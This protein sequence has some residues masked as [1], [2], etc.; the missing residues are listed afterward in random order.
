MRPHQW[1]KNSFVLAPLVFAQRLDD[2]DSLVRALAATA[3]F[4]VVSG[5][6]YL[7]NDAA[8]I[9]KDRAHPTKRNRPIPSGRLSVRAAL[10][11]SAILATSAVGL[12]LL[13][14]WEFSAA[15]ALYF[16]V[17]LAYSRRLKHIP[18]V[19]VLTIAFGF[20]IRIV[21]GALAIA[22]PLSPWIFACTFL[23]ALYMGMGKRRHEI[24]EAAHN[25]EKQR[26]VLEAYHLGSLT[27]F[28]LGTAMATVA[29]YTAYAVED[30]TADFGTDL[31]WT[32]IP[33]C[34]IGLLRF[35]KL[36]GDTSTPSSPTEQIT[37]DLPFLAN[38][39]TWGVLMVY[40]IYFA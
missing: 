33:F 27:T 20:L 36:S 38:L 1:V 17:N 32:T 15:T 34:A 8:D 26:K 28:M 13:L 10:R 25:A 21:A 29:A 35:F 16:T 39:G 2:P 30:H 40:L 37:R 18:Y 7:M 4:C 6:V 5:S 23:L 31:L 22:V 19:D 3:L 24:I 9:E 11:A 12:G 14:G